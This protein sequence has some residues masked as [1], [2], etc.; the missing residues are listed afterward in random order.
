M[1][2]VY[3]L[4]AHWQGYLLHAEYDDLLDEAEAQL[5]DR[6]KEDNCLLGCREVTAGEVYTT[7]HDVRE[8]GVGPQVCRGFTFD[9]RGSA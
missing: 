8:Y 2:A 9:V 5:I 1:K 4:P 7:H 6:F 3:T